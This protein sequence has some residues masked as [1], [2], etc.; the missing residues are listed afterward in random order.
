MRELKLFVVEDDLAS[1]QL[2]TE[3]FRSRKANV[4]PVSD[5]EEAAR[6]VNQEKFDGIFLDLEMPKLSGL[7][8]A[9]GPIPYF[10]T[11]W[12]PERFSRLLVHPS[13]NCRFASS[14]TTKRNKC[15]IGP[16]TRWKLRDRPQR[17][18]TPS[19][20]RSGNHNGSPPTGENIA[21]VLIDGILSAIACGC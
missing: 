13:T 18:A 1:L 12:L 5:G 6:R 8:L 20:G 15:D 9:R 14:L 10:L 21:I 7:Y 2:M 16:N 4:R 19:T 11:L 3:V 17:S